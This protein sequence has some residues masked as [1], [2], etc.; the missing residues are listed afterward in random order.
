MPTVECRGQ[1]VTC[2]HGD[3][4]RDVLLDAGLTP[5]DGS[6]DGLNCRG[7]GSCGTCAVAVT[8]AVSDP[9][10]RERLRLRVPPH[11]ADSGLRLACQA[12]VLGDVTVTKYPG[13]WGQHVDEAPVGT[14][15]GASVGAEDAEPV[16]RDDETTASDDDGE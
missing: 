14:D 2:D 3:V 11:D 15:D 16:G 12:R 4:L 8:G 7:H 10:R 9:S 5:H 13:F 1:S 6:A